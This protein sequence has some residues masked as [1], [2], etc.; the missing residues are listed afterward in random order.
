MAW[1]LG[2]NSWVFAESRHKYEFTSLLSHYRS[3]LSCAQIALND[4]A[5]LMQIYLGSSF[6]GQKTDGSTTTC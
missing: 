2:L 1:G 6:Y 5:T 4:T 3:N